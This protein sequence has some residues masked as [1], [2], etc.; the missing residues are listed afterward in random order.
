MSILVVAS[1]GEQSQA[2][3]FLHL[4]AGATAVLGASDSIEIAPLGVFEREARGK[5]ETVC[6]VVVKDAEGSPQGD[7]GTRARNLEGVLKT[8]LAAGGL[9]DAEVR[10]LATVPG[11]PGRSEISRSAARGP[12]P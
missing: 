6:A 5:T 10:V 3:A 8:M 9:A 2:T 11:Q 4:L 7:A 12:N 1:L